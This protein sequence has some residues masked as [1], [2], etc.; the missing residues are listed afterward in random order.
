VRESSLADDFSLVA[1]V[2]ICDA[3]ASGSLSAQLQEIGLELANHLSPGEYGGG[4]ASTP[5]RSR[6]LL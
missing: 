1:A 5:N 2:R 6:R 4:V 3:L